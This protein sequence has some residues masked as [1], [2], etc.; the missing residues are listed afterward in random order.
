MEIEEKRKLEHQLVDILKK[1][2]ECDNIVDE[3]NKQLAIAIKEICGE[4]EK[5]DSVQNSKVDKVSKEFGKRVAKIVII[6]DNLFEKGLEI[7]RTLENEA[8]VEQEETRFGE[9]DDNGRPIGYIRVHGK[10][11]KRKP[12]Q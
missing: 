5:L 10:W 12:K 6:R 3:Y 2:E 11:K 8:E 4:H 9:L 7:Q 1:I